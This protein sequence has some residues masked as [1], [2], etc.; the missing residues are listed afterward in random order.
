MPS[1]RLSTPHAPVAMALS[2][3]GEEAENTVRILLDWARATYPDWFSR[4][5]PAVEVIPWPKGAAASSRFTN[6]G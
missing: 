5:E 2:R 4:C 6:P 1:R 3:P